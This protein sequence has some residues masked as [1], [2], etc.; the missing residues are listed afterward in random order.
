MSNTRDSI[1]LFSL[2]PGEVTQD[3][4]SFDPDTLT[5]DQQLIAAIRSGEDGLFDAAQIVDEADVYTHGHSERVAKYAVALARELDFSEERVATIHKAGLLHDLG[6][7]LVNREILRKPGALNEEEAMEM[8]RHPEMAAVILESVPELAEIARIVRYHHE[9]VD[10]R[11]YPGRLKGAEIPEEARLLTVTDSY[12]AMVSSRPYRKALDIDDALT[13]LRRGAG[14]QFDTV[15]V[16]TF[17]QMITD[18]AAHRMTFLGAAT[19]YAELA[20]REHERA[21]RFI[22]RKF[23]LETVDE[24]AE[25]LGQEFPE[26]GPEE[27]QKIVTVT[28]GHGNL[29]DDF[30]SDEVTRPKEDERI[31][32]HPARIDADVNSVVSFEGKLFNVLDISELEDGR[33]RYF[34]KR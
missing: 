13:Q 12:D 6:K 9:R 33:F 28:L 30:Y 29:R 20:I 31:V 5:V 8:A 19:F 4:L 22:A 16:S 34:L 3:D 2:I 21:A 7:A 11:G 25:L 1:G 27:A 10:G 15:Y 17:V 26:L 23:H 18:R 32:L 24:V 14:S